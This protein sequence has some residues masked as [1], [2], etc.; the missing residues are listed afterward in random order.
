[1]RDALVAGVVAGLIVAGLTVGL[2]YRVPATQPVVQAAVRTSEVGRYQI[3]NGTPQFAI[4]IMLLDTVTGDSWIKCASPDAGD[5]WCSVL[6][7]EG[8]TAPNPKK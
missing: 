1:M 6:R 3:I 4:N 2:N 7:L 8:H 5:N